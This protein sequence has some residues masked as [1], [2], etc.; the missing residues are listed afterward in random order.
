MEVDQQE[1]SFGEPRVSVEP[2][3]DAEQSKTP[4]TTTTVTIDTTLASIGSNPNS[5]N[6]YQKQLQQSRMILQQFPKP[7]KVEASKL[8]FLEPLTNFEIV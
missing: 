1:V 2:K 3:L 4:N 5:A 8:P 6:N 7:P